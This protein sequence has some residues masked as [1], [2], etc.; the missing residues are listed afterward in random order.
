MTSPFLVYGLRDPVTQGIRYV[1]RSSSGLT[2]PKEHQCP[3]KLAKDGTYKG[4]WLRKLYATGQKAEIVVLEEFSSTAEASI[5][6]A[7]WISLLKTSALTNL[8]GGGDGPGAGRIVSEATRK[9]LRVSSL[10]QFSDPAQVELVRQ[11]AVFRWQS[12]DNRKKQS[13]IFKGRTFSAETIKHMEAAARK[14]EIF[15]TPESRG[16]IQAALNSPE[17]KA[18]AAAAASGRALTPEGKKHLRSMQVASQARASVIKRARALGGRPFVD[19][20]GNRYELISDAAKTLGVTAGNIGSVLKGRLK[21]TKGYI[22]T[23]IQ[24]G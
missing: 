24:N 13:E 4:N 14:R 15:R 10:K 17:A 20:K 7:K 16:I 19:Q 1:G 21:Q 6:E 9:K 11:R 3:S 12:V 22:F 2:R 23:Y 5:G 18:K 8:T